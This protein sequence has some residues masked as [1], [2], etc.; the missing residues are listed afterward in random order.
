M[1]SKSPIL[2]PDDLQYVIQR[3]K[4]RIDKYGL[5]FESLCSGSPE[6][7]QLRHSVHATA[8]KGDRPELLDIGCGLGDFYMF[9]K[10]QGITCVYTGYDIV[11]E[12]IEKCLS[13]FPESNFELRNILDRGINGDFDSIVMSQVFNNN[14]S[15]S[16]NFEVICEAIRL[17]FAHTR[18]S[19][20]VDM[21]STYVDYQNPVLF[22]YSPEDMFR[23]ARSITPRVCI[24]HDY[25]LYEY[26][27]Q[28]FHFE[29]EGFIP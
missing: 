5:I 21:L 28:L 2:H 9:L 16:D 12:Y 24:R 7:Q 13:T 10:Q 20:S 27:L 29:S 3:Y 25:R 26:C 18:I 15:H 23:F 1:S 11:P 17:A 4:E 19:V 6:K 14:Y 22:Y 8:L